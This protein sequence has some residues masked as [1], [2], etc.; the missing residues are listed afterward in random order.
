MLENLRPAPE[1]PNVPLTANKSP[2]RAPLRRSAVPCGTWPS[3]CMVT[4][5][6]PRVV[7]PPTNATP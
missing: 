1:S 2:A 5:S 4:V 6:G 3:S 7:S